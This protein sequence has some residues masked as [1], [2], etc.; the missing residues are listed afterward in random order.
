[1]TSERQLERE[2][3]NLKLMRDSSIAAARAKVP[4]A[5]TVGPEFCVECE[6]DIPEARRNMG[7]DLCVS[8]A[9]LAERRR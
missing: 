8:C 6:D 2:E 9:S 1:M 3:E 4:P 5:G 7:Y